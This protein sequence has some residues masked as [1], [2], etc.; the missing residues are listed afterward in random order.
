MTLKIN[1]ATM[2]WLWLD[3][4]GLLE[5][6]DSP[7]DVVAIIQKLGFVQLDTIQN[8]SRAHHHILWSRH[9]D[10]RES[11]LDEILKERK[12][13]FEHF[14]HDASVLPMDI[15]PMWQKRI[16][17]MKTKIHNASWHNPERVK[18]WKDTLLER[19]R[20]EGPL[21]TKDF[22]SAINGEKKVWSRPPHKQV[23][24]YL[25]YT[26]HLSTSHR[27]KFLKYYDVTDRVIPPAFLEQNVPESEQINSLCRAALERL[28]VGS[29]KE[30]RAFWDAVDPAE[31]KNWASEIEDTL[32]PVTW[33]TANGDWMNSYALKG[34]E[35]KLDAL[36]DVPAKMKILNPFD[37]L[38]R[39]RDRL[40]AL[41]GFEY[42]LEVFVPEA[43]RKW[44]YYVYP[45]L[46]GDRFVGRI[47]AKA[48]R[49]GGCLN[50]LNFWPE[51]GVRWGKNRQKKLD[52]ELKRFAR[53]AE[54]K[55]VAWRA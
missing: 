5:Q 2:R 48:D 33:E 21:S 12:H 41:F 46:E 3:S 17:R 47:E 6:P 53:L 11:M 18:E 35:D 30:I 9:R 40:N 7:V 29:L 1:N 34:L 45:L 51:E 31:V 15:Y 42:K 14:T 28:T 13:I 49:K 38:V 43:K 8:V 24:D 16:K 39:D 52:A 4:N 22:T 44:G 20:E 36:Q 37:P 32:L 27:E 50:I 54:M 25:W 10:Y 19:I 23:L 55:T 26:G